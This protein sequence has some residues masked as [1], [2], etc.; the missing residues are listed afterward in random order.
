LRIHRE[1][2]LSIETR[3]EP[4][5]AFRGER[6]D[7]EE[8]LGNLM[9]NACKWA[10]ARVRV[11]A[12]R[13][14]GTL[15]VSVEDDGPGLS[16]PERAAL[17]HRGKR[18]DESVPGTGLG[19]AIVREIAEHYAGEVTL[20]ASSLGGLGAVLTLPAAESLA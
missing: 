18:L 9:D 8:M 15:R 14:G 1:R 19:L 7:V 13:E 3:C 2:P 12:R 5:L 4:G 10:R 17:F 16:E 11:M 20:E 6:Q